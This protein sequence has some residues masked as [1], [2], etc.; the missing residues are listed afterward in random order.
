M[1]KWNIFRAV[2]LKKAEDAKGF[3]KRKK[4]SEPVDRKLPFDIRIG[5]SISFDQTPFILYGDKMKITSPGKECIV[6][7]Y[8][9]IELAG[10]V[11]H[12]F[13]LYENQDKENTS[14]LQI[15]VDM[16]DSNDNFQEITECRLFKIE[17][18]IFPQSEEEWGFWL[19]EKDG[20]IGWHSFEDKSGNVYEIAWADDDNADRS[21]PVYFS[22][23]LY[24]DKYGENISVIDNTAMLYGR[25]IDEDN[26]IAE[27]AFIS[28][29]ESGNDSGFIRIYIG[30]D[31]IQGSFKV[32]Y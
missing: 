27:L 1:S 15:V 20:Y 18:E 3:F 23:T 21:E 13:Y 31:I 16:H 6:A 4:K 29:E 5:S 10:S 22:E 2:T 26:D 12:R 32:N 11:I 9:K 8:G 28:A 17:D 24:I 14:F 30:I 25:M 19:D 7:A